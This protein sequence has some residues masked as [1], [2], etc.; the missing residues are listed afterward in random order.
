MSN[1][2]KHPCYRIHAWLH[3]ITGSRVPHSLT[4][5][6]AWISRLS[7]VLAAT[8]LTLLGFANPTDQRLDP[9]ILPLASKF[10]ANRFAIACVLL[11]VQLSCRTL[12]GVARFGQRLNLRAITAVLDNLV[13][14]HF[15][16]QDLAAH[17][18]RATLFKV[19][20]CWPVGYW[21]GAIARSGHMYPKMHAVFSINPS[22]RMNNTGFAG[23]CWRQN[24][25]TIIPP[26]PL[27]DQRADGL[28]DAC[29]EEY[30]VNGYLADEEYDTMSVKSQVFL[31]TGIKVNGKLWGILVLDSTDPKAHPA[32][33]D[34][35]KDRED[36]LEFAAL[37]LS[38]L[39]E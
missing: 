7:L 29:R 35:R 34:T 39:V 18:Y 23:E 3:C 2:R 6:I 36:Y 5:S 11:V 21:L 25:K 13:T 9:D 30:K 12:L 8:F 4:W 20:W 32:S 15:L 33:P 1:R 28:T 31:A 38:L 24:G 26:D 27:P 14:R 37:S 22:I 17:V 16:R 19:C 10:Y